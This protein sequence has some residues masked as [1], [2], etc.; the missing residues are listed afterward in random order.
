MSPKLALLLLLGLCALALAVPEGAEPQADAVA[1]QDAGAEESR[2]VAP[3]EEEK[4]EEETQS[5]ERNDESISEDDNA[6]VDLQNTEDVAKKGQPGQ[7]KRKGYY[8]VFLPFK[9]QCPRGPRGPRGFRGLR[10]PRGFRGL[11]GQRGARGLRGPRGLRGVQGPRGLRGLRGSR[12][13]KGARGATGLRGPRGLKGQK[14][15]RGQRG[16]PG[17]GRRL[18]CRPVSAKGNRA[19]CP[20]GF[21]VT[22]C[23]CGHRCGSWNTENGNT[24]C[25]CHIGCMNGNK[26][27]DWTLAVCC[28][29][30]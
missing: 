8:G 13:P 25:Y 7:S 20:S 21:T 6:P 17:P 16:P 11:R 3:A 4:E 19:Q 27:L 24:R 2:E 18:D 22:G 26:P 15:D 12:G 29:V 1:T 28:K 9:C 30:V 5:D 14:G 23:A 10:G